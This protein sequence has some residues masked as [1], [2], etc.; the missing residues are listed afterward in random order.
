LASRGSAAD[1]V[2]LL[3]DNGCDME[4]R[5]I[6]GFKPKD[7]VQDNSVKQ[8]YIDKY[9]V[10]HLDSQKEGGRYLKD[11]EHLPWIPSVV[12]KWSM[13]RKDETKA[14]KPGRCDCFWKQIQKFKDKVMPGSGEQSRRTINGVIKTLEAGE[15]DVRMVTG[16]EKQFTYIML[17]MHPNILQREA[18]NINLKVKR[19]DIDLKMDFKQEFAHKFEPFRSKD[20]QEII[21]TILKR[22]LNLPSFTRRKWLNQIILM[23]DPYGLGELKER[24]YNVKSAKR[25]VLMPIRIVKEL[26]S[27]GNTNE[28]KELTAVKDYFGEKVGFNVAWISFYTAWLFVPGIIG[29]TLTLYQ[30]STGNVE[31]LYSPLY[32]I[33]IA[34]W[35]TVLIEMWKRK[36]S[37][38]ASKWGVIDI[39]RVDE[40]REG[41]IG[42]EYHSKTTLQVGKRS[43]T[44]HPTLIFL[45]S[46]PILLALLTACVVIFTYATRFKNAAAKEDAR[47]NQ[48]GEEVVEEGTWIE[49]NFGLIAGVL[50]G[51]AIAVVD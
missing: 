8:V 24:W 9:M 10:A 28:M 35:A 16:V 21:L 5:N 2:K 46:L 50:N 47:V 26:I 42:D 44:M 31:S 7:L 25:F 6:A 14:R 1:V 51:M 4:K 43:S 29:L 30:L 41:Y 22:I 49:K 48:V 17:D 20:K 18:E 33:S 32:S 39:Q 13:P 37:E 36:S 11:F 38:I 15:F 27:E 19:V 3:L 34:I 23:H 40:I 12:L 45:I